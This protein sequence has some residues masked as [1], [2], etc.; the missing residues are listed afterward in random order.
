M[1]E[2]TGHYVRKKDDWAIVERG[3][4]VCE[5]RRKCKFNVN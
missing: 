1:G 4:N 5:N 2:K 3:V